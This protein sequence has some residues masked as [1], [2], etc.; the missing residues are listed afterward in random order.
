MLLHVISQSLKSREVRIEKYKTSS[1][2]SYTF[3][4]GV[5]TRELVTE[6]G[7]HYLYD[8]VGVCILLVEVQFVAVLQFT[9]TCT[10]QIPILIVG[11]TTFIRNL[12][13][14][15]VPG[16]HVNGFYSVVTS[17]LNC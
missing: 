14:Q 5:G 17:D 12:H 9:T 4:V 16:W 1:F 10:V 8:V 13:Q 11:N 15:T 7:P 6:L 2:L 3:P